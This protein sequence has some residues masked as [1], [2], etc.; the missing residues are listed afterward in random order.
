[1]L[2]QLMTKPAFG[3]LGQKPLSPILPLLWIHRLIA[4]LNSRSACSTSSGL[5]N[6]EQQFQIE[7]EVRLQTKTAEILLMF[8]ILQSFHVHTQGLLQDQLSLRLSSFFNFAL[9]NYISLHS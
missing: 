5:E 3:G 2:T 6:L 7:F 8:F 9:K 4:D 1:M